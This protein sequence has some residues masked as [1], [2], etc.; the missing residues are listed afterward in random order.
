[1]SDKKA[2]RIPTYTYLGIA[3]LSKMQILGPH[4]KLM[5]SETGCRFLLTSPL[6]DSATHS[7]V[8]TTGLEAISCQRREWGLDWTLHWKELG[9]CW[10]KWNHAQRQCKVCRA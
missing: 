10:A 4:S 1:M 6:G 8:K 7:S 9:E 5:V 2:L 3:F